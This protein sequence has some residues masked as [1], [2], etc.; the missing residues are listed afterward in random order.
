MSFKALF[1]AEAWKFS[2]V[3]QIFL[4]AVVVEKGGESRDSQGYGE[5]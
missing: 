5:I 2:R 3:W 1:F 4:A